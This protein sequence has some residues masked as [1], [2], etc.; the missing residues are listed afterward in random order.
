MARKQLNAGTI[1]SALI[2]SA[3]IFAGGMLLGFSINKER[4][5]TVEEDMK[6]ITRHVQ[7]FQLQ[8]LF[9][10]VLGDSATCPLLSATL[11][12]IN[13][14]SYEIGAKLTTQGEEGQVQ[15]Y[16]A[17]NGLKSEYSRLLVS[18]WLLTQKLQES[19]EM[20]AKTVIYFYRKECPSCDD[21][22]FILTY[23]KR[24]YGEKLL[25]FALDADISDAS[26]KTL[27]NYYNVSDYPALIVDGELHQGF[28]SQEQL[29]AMLGLNGA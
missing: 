21:Q 16:D 15:D 25:I 4:L 2:I 1:I 17:Y 3:L 27:I 7:N 12:D 28:Y 9:F 11:A 14:A 8:F 5:S 6:E 29:M 22:G 23:L 26:V 24:K 20:E 13:K 18:Y 10:D 19:C